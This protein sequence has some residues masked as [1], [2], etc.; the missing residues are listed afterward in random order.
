MK[1]NEL[2][3][4]ADG[5]KDEARFKKLMRAAAKKAGLK[6]S[7]IDA[8][9]R[10]DRISVS[11]GFLK[12]LNDESFSFKDAFEVLGK[13][14]I[15]S[16]PEKLIGVKIPNF[17]KSP[18]TSLASALKNFKDTPATSDNVSISFAFKPN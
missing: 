9:A 12:P 6:P 15:A 2:I 5:K 18:E 4:E 16:A 8:W 14:L 11:G 17:E 13:E 1:I 10:N 3:T 7:H